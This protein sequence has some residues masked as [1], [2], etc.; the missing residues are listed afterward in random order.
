[1]WIDLGKDYDSVKLFHLALDEGITITPGYIFSATNKYRN[2]IRLSYGLPW[3]E[4]LEHA[5]AKL[6]ELLH[7]AKK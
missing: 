3:S 5:I 7:L 1:V 4:R 2:C 6:G